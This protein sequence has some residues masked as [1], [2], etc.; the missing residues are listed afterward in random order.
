MSVWYLD[1]GDEI[2]DAVA[3][4]RAATD[5][6]VVLVVPPGSRIAT[7][8]INF[9]LLS[10]EAGSRGLVLAIVSPDK[11]VRA[12]AT[13]AG[14]PAHAS[15]ADAEEALARGDVEPRPEEPRP[16]V[17]AE[18]SGSGEVSDR[19]LFADLAASEEAAT[20]LRRGHR[21]RVGAAAGVVVG[22]VAIGGVAALT[23]LPSAT[24]TIRPLTEALGPITLPVTA[25]PAA[26]SID[27]V[28][29]LVPATLVEIPLAVQGRF[30]A[31]GR[32]TRETRAGGEV[33]FSWQAP[34]F[35][36]EIAA[37]TR[38]RTAEGIEF[39][40]TLSVL[41]RRPDQGTGPAEVSVAVEAVAAGPQGNV[42]A[43]AISVVSS[44]EAQG[45]RVTNPAPTSGG[46][47]E[48]TP[49]ITSDDY[50]AAAVD[51]Q[52]RLAGELA[53]R[54]GDPASVPP[55]L[56]LFPET[57]RRGDVM[58]VPGREELVGRELAEFELSAEASAVALAVDERI[59]EQVALQRL[60]AAA[61]PGTALLAATAR[62]DTG[63]G[64]SGDGVIRYTVT[65]E[66][67]V[68]LLLD[69]DELLRKVR[70]KPIPEA[71]SILE[72]HG[73]A[74][75]TVW[76]EFLGN[77]P[78]DVNRIRLTVLEPEVVPAQMPA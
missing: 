40:T 11:Q 2:T 70:G 71:R 8:R 24:I 31:S 26:E 42:P 25:D 9:R 73:D 57:A 77:L 7:G 72:D 69:P 47:R 29:G 59:V 55:G 15:V 5:D 75:I 58:T 16:V 14:L 53:R 60:V 66:G 12:L 23:V 50:T 22:L 13:A 61:R 52:N 67:R 30:T 19:V 54:L 46:Q 10:R 65:A 33:T 64:I 20:Y 27:P 74:R 41:L 4:L 44:L 39:E 17:P 21:R 63:K 28:A 18:A 43:G 76:P 56:T 78:D 49:V 38:V 3:R 48:E 68:Q 32:E 35:D 51:L 45:I 6:Q 34:L 62:V 1:I 37:G 36:V